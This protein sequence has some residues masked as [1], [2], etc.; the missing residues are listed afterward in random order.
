MY[1][2]CHH[3]NNTHFRNIL[4][5][6]DA[7]FPVQVHFFVSSEL[8]NC[9]LLKWWLDHPMSYSHYHCHY[10]YYYVILVHAYNHSNTHYYEMM[11]N[12]YIYIYIHIYIYTHLYTYMIILSLSLYIYIYIIHDRPMSYRCSSP[13]S[14]GY[15]RTRRCR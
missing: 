12:T 9:W 4:N 3:F 10:H 7:L 2:F 11:A 15:R 5:I 6:N 8:L 14:R 1:V 13:R